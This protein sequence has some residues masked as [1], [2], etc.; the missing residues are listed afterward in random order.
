MPTH[1]RYSHPARRS[2]RLSE[3]SRRVI[4]AAEQM[5]VALRHPTVGLGHLLLA[6]LLETRSPAS[7]LLL[8]SGLDEIRLRNGLLERDPILLMNIEPILTQ[9]LISGSPYIGTE[10]LLR[11]FTLDPQGVTLLAAYGIKTDDL[12]NRLI[13]ESG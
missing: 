8:E 10:H 12:R 11:T 5:S 7:I 4:T 3:L 9:A 1:S 13:A 2:A 6:L